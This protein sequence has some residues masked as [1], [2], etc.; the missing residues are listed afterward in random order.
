MPCREWADRTM[1]TIRSPAAAFKSQ[2]G[3]TGLG[4]LPE[5]DE[6]CRQQDLRHEHSMPQRAQL[7]LHLLHPAHSADPCIGTGQVCSSKLYLSEARAPQL[8]A[9]WMALSFPGQCM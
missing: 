9:Q 3:E 2:A 6:G 5:E 4:H 7:R 8:S 1:S